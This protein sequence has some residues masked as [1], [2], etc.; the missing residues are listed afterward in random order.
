[1]VCK[2]ETCVINEHEYSV[3]QWPAEKAMLMKFKLIKAFGAPLMT[4]VKADSANTDDGI[5]DA[6]MDLFSDTKPEELV[7]LIK[8]CVTGA[9]RDGTRMIESAFDD[10]FSGDSLSEVYRVF[11]FVIRVN[12][13]N[14]LGGQ[15]VGDLL[16]KTT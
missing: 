10:Y 4:L 15:S 7:A 6:F 11:G 3:T 13:A 12:Y 16:A 14:L 5:G 8:Q 9:A 1:M 2:T